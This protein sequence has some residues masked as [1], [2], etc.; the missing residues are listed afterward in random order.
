MNKVYRYTITTL[1]P[2]HIGVGEAMTPLEYYIA[3]ELIVPD[4]GRVFAKYPDAAERFNRSLAAKSAHDLAR[5]GLGELI[6]ADALKDPGARRYFLIEF[7]DS[8]TKFG[9]FDELEDAIPRGQA[10]VKL[11]IKT[12]DHHPYIPGSSIKGAFKTAWA[13]AQLKQDR[14][15]LDYVIADPS[16]G[17]LSSRVFHAP[18]QKGDAAKRINRAK[19][20]AYDVFRALHFGDSK[21]A[22]GDDVFVLAAERVLSAGVASRG[23][24]VKGKDRL[25]AE[26]KDYWTFCEAIDEKMNFNGRLDFCDSLLTDERAQRALGWNESQRSLTPS[27]LCRAVNDFAADLCQWEIEYFRQIAAGAEGRCQVEQ[28]LRFYE[29]LKGEIEE[30]GADTCY[31]SLGHGSGWHKLTVGLL[32]E[33]HLDRKSFAGLRQK[34][35][36][37]DR[38]TDYEYPKSRK[39][40]MNGKRS[41]YSPFGW[42]KMNLIPPQN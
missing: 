25:R 37:A 40:V 12:P 24:E 18:E 19:D 30:A 39:L 4:L 34:L 9:S 32:L 33:K 10:E 11:A 28:A 17:A 21:P 23:G 14:K 3:D 6:P 31:F 7:Y 41:A 27:S 38:H 2:A 15:A 16:D 5:I 36:L 20:A 26:F 13:Y 42:V 8:D 1:A 29:D 35:R 22:E